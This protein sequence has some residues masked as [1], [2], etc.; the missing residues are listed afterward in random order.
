MFVY[1]GLLALT[2]WQ[3]ATA[4]IGFVPQQ[5]KGYLLIN[6]MLPDSASVQ[7]TQ[8]VMARIDRIQNCG[9]VQAWSGYRR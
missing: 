4:P 1:G 7:R 6:V 5:D 9:T 2:G 8:K 3:F